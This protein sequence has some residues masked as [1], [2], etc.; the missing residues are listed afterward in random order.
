MGTLYQ[1]R[2]RGAAVSDALADARYA[3]ARLLQVLILRGAGLLVLLCTLA[4]GLALASYSPGDP[5][6]NNAT[7]RDVANWLG[8]FGAT[9]A[10][11]LLQA[12]GIAAFAFIAPIAVWGTRALLGLGFSLVVWCVFVWLFGFVLVAAGLGWLLWFVV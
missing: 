10:D 11:V 1:P 2:S 5:S 3:L 6:L 12:F 7:G 9:A 8:P 4:V